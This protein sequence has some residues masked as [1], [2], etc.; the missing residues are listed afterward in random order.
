MPTG[1]IDAATVSWTIESGK[2]AVRSVSRAWDKRPAR[3]H[4]YHLSPLVQRFLGAGIGARSLA[5]VLS[6]V[7]HGAHAT[8]ID[9]HA[10]RSLSFR[11][12]VCGY[13]SMPFS[14]S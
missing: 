5:G 12:N 10:S 11:V 2:T 8:W 9:S 13:D 1:G 3:G 14:L 6:R 7:G 4:G